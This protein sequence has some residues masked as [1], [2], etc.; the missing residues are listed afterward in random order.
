VLVELWRIPQSTFN[1]ANEDTRKIEHAVKFVNERYF[2][3]CTNDSGMI[4]HAYWGH[5][6]NMRTLKVHE[7]EQWRDG[8]SFNLT[9]SIGNL[10]FDWESQKFEFEWFQDEQNGPS[11][12][13]IKAIKRGTVEWRTT[14]EVKDIRND[15]EGSSVKSLA[16]R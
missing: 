13:L 8:G 4:T 9:T 5:P 2:L 7:Y 10:N 15:V 3:A 16:G 1:M 14:E 11:E 12:E 6:G